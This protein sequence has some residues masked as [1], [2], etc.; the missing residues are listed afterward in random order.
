MWSKTGE[1]N[2][3]NSTPVMSAVAGLWKAGNVKSTCFCFGPAFVFSSQPYC[4]LMS[5]SGRHL[6]CLTCVSEALTQFSAWRRE[7]KERVNEKIG[8]LQGDLLL[9]CRS[10]QWALTSPSSVN[11]VLLLFSNFQPFLSKYFHLVLSPWRKGDV[12]GVLINFWH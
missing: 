4:P 10:D 3:S 9:I 7:R 5:L 6:V 1:P 8:L 11:G 2:P 12:T